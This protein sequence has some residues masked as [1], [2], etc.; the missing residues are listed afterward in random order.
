MLLSRELTSMNRIEALTK[1]LEHGIYSLQECLNSTI[2]TEA[3]VELE[4]TS[5]R[6]AKA[7]ALFLREVPIK[8]Y[9]EEL[10]VGIPFIEK[11]HDNFESDG[12]VRSL[13]PES[14]SGQGYIDGALNNLNLGLSEPYEPVIQA[15]EGYGANSRYGSFPS[16]ATEEEVEIARRVGLAE[17]SNPGHLQAGFARAVGMGWSGLKE[18]AEEQLM[19]VDS[20]Y[21][22][23]GKRSAFLRSV[24][25]SLEAAMDFSKKYADLADK[26]VR[27]EE[28]SRRRMELREISRVCHKISHE[29]PVTFQEALQLLWFTHI[30]NNTQGARQLGRFDQYMYPF[31]KRDLDSGTL[32]EEEAQELIDCLWIKF[33]GLTD[34]TM[35][36]L[37]NLILGG[38]TPDGQDATN[39][40]SYI[41]LNATESLGL[42]DPK[43]SVRV[44]KDTPNGFL[45]KICEL[46]AKGEY[47]PGIY[48]DEAIIP[49]LVRSG[50]PLEDSRDYT[51]DGCSEILVQGKTCPWA[52]EA[53]VKLLKC[54]ELATNRLEDFETFENLLNAT[55]DEI[56]L[57]VNMAVASVNILQAAVPKISPN[58]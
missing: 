29:P 54:M 20:K 43:V 25:I 27:K 39:L 9:S 51:N 16:Y 36:N 56:S 34:V 10:I 15:L 4:P 19:K 11:P 55:K 41:C 1:N 33:A 49:A 24:I 23:P 6:K 50:I 58:P 32:S 48:N 42:I 31:L 40:L 7:L 57:A 28:D 21:S 38:Q 3:G 26:L 17:N 14:V 53:N 12:V 22:E 45:R 44:H 35:D 37:Q 46:I 5:V 2:F 52:F 30:I 18:I 8:I 13:P 47:Q